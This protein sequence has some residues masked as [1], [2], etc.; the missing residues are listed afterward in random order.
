MGS[1]IAAGVRAATGASVLILAADQPAVDAALLRQLVA[2]MEAGHAR[3]ACAYAGIVG[4]PALF[5]SADDLAVLR[6]LTGDR[7]AR[8]LLREGGDDLLAISA[9]QAAIDIDEPEDWERWLAASSSED[10]PSDPS[11]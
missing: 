7:G 3:V 1:S 11:D 2:G 9:E 8:V 4:I 5:S 10:A 6:G